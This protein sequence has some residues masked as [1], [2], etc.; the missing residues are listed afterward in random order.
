MRKIV[1][2]VAFFPFT[3]VLLIANLSMLA[4]Y[5][6]SENAKRLSASIPSQTSFNL[7]AAGNTSQV[8]NATV[9]AADARAL[10]LRSFMSKHKSPMT[11]YADSIVSEADRYGIDFRLVPAIAMCE[12]NLGKHMPAHDSYNPFG[13]AVY[14]GQQSGKMFDSWLSSIQWVSKYIKEHYYD[15][16]LVDLKDIGAVW[17]PPSV[18]TGY[19]WSNCVQ[20]FM[21]SIA[22]NPS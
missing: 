1:L 12:S 13:I 10:L 21:D 3:I 22:T 17:A 7:T 8:I 2:V 5:S 14:T 9:I 18:N 6:R 15:R 4:Y 19:S 16:G 20:K 11:D